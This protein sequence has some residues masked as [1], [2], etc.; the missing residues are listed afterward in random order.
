MATVKKVEGSASYDTCS[1]GDDNWKRTDP[2][3]Y[4]C[5]MS[6]TGFAI[7]TTDPAE[8]LTEL[9]RSLLTLGWESHSILVREKL[10]DPDERGTS[11]LRGVYFKGRESRPF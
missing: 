10:E 2:Y 4:Q 6:L 5:A 1:E 8:E 11:C 9:D 3:H 7:L